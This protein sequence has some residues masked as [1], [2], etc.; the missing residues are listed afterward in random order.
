MAL[1]AGSQKAWMAAL[2]GFA[3]AFV[4][5]LFAGGDFQLDTEINVL[6]ALLSDLV[7]STFFAGVTFA[8][9]YLKRNIAADGTP[10]Q[11]VKPTGVIVDGAGN[12]I[13]A[14]PKTGATAYTSSPALVGVA[15]VALV[16]L[17]GCETI[18]ARTGYSQE[19]QVCIAQTTYAVWDLPISWQE[20]MGAVAEA[21]DVF[22]GPELQQEMQEAVAEEEPAIGQGR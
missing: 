17:A 3:S 13:G 1:F 5:Q 8:I 10:M 19:Q 20:K 21:C 14:L 15:A 4:A 2:G 22:K 12:S 6:G 16:A 11:F 9:A 18:T 7:V